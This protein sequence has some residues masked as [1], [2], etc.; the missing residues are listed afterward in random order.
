MKTKHAPE[1]LELE[2]QLW[3]WFR[4]NE[5][6]HAAITE[7]LL[8]MKALCLAHY[9][10]LILERQTDGSETLKSGMVSAN[11]LAKQVQ[12]IKSMQKLPKWVFL[13][14][15]RELIRT[16]CIIWMRLGGTIDRFQNGHLRLSHAKVL[17]KPKIE[18]LLFC[19]ATL[20]GPTSL[21]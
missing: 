2:N 1:F 13:R 16:M 21:K 18:S 6:K 7:D 8:K 19:A 17:K 9:S 11:L 4:R 15:F 20:Q 14:F 10:S 5:S 12:P 3:A